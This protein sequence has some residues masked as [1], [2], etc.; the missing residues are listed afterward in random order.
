MSK[1][2]FLNYLNDFDNGVTLTWNNRDF[3]KLNTNVIMDLTYNVKY[4]KGIDF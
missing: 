1:T 4:I 3:I 2:W